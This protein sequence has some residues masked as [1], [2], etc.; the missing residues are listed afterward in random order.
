MKFGLILIGL[1]SVSTCFSK[2]C[3]E[4]LLG[5]QFDSNTHQVY[6][7]QNVSDDVRANRLAYSKAA[8]N[9]LT[10]ILDCAPEELKFQGKTSCKEIL[11]G[12]QRS[13]VC[14]I[15]ANLGYFL[16]AI[17]YMENINIT[18]NRWD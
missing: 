11:P 4:K 14:Y 13:K 10:Q 1:L 2:D 16:V 12:Y 3:Y 7:L 5:N 18:F 17:D 8:I 15:E 9:R 6:E